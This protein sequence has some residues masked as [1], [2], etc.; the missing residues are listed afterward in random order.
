MSASP[1]APAVEGNADLGPEARQRRIRDRYIGARFP[2]VAR[3]TADLSPPPRV[4]KA[5]SAHLA[6]SLIPVEYLK[7]QRDEER[8][9]PTDEK[10]S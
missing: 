5:A 10:G 3:S 6:S 1:A 4:I 2:G 7:D 9:A 8:D